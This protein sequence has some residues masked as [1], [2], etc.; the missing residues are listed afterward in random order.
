MKLLLQDLKFSQTENVE[1]HIW[2][3]TFYNVIELLRKGQSEDI[4][5][6][7]KELHKKTL[8]AVIEDGIK[9]FENLLTVLQE[10]YTFSI[11]ELTGTSAPMLS[12]MPNKFSPFTNLAIISA[13]KVCLFMGDLA[14]YKEQAND[15]TNFNKAK[16]WYTKAQMLNPKN[17][18]PY[19][20]LAILAIYAVRYLFDAFSYNRC[21][22]WKKFGPMS[23]SFVLRCVVNK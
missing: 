23:S 1:Q 21:I 4:S 11:E 12:Q 5:A 7:L 10:S 15:T 2:K 17:G 9:F 22:V 8:L 3:L 16:Q 20:Q 14:R 18:R 13:Q 19:N 6:E